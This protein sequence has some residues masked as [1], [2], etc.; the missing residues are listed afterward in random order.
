MIIGDP[1]GLYLTLTTSVV[2]SLGSKLHPFE[3]NAWTFAI[4]VMSSGRFRASLRAVISTLQVLKL[5][6]D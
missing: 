5:I 6:T 3:L 2:S 4:I 1:E